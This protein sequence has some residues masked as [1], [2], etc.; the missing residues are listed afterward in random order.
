MHNLDDPKLYERLDPSG[1]RGRLREFPRHCRIAWEG[2]AGTSLPAS[3][4]NVERVVVLGMGGSAIGGDLL[5]DFCAAEQVALQVWVSREYTPPSWVDSKT[6]VIASSYSGET[7]E[8]LSSFLQA[9]K[10]GATIVALAHGGKLMA[11]AQEA[12]FPVVPIPYRSEPRTALAYGFLPLLRLVCLLGLGRDYSSDVA[13][14][15]SVLARLVQ[16]LDTNVPQ[17]QNPAK[18]LAMRLAGKVGVVYGAG[19][20]SGAARRWKTQLN[21]NAKAWAFYEPLPEACHNAIEGYQFPERPD[22]HF[23]VLLRSPLLHPEVL[24]RYQP[25]MEI[26]GRLQVPNEMVESRGQSSL[27]HILSTV[28]MG[29]YVSYYVGLL[30]GVDPSSTD[31]IAAFKGRLAQKG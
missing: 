30:N 10:A 29:D 11:L 24:A 14:A 25:L 28:L 23:V 3:Y 20:L 1:L 4:R 18:G 31:T 2:S 12:V 22:Q 15:E 5:A 8:T 7:A 9:R 21:E 16:E 13:E 6:L 26:L 17:E 19:L 27:A